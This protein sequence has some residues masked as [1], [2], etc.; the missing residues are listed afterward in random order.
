MSHPH[1]VQIN[2]TTYCGGGFTDDVKAD[3]QVFQYNSDRN[4]WSALPKCPTRYHALVELNGNLIT[5]GGVEHDAPLGAPT[6]SVYVLEDLQWRK[7]MPP[8][9][10]ARYYASA[11]TYDS[12]AIVCGGVTSW[13]SVDQFTCTATVEVYSS[14]TNQWAMSSPL[15]FALR[16]MSTAVVNDSHWRRMSR[17]YGQGGCL[18]PTSCTNEISRGSPSRRLPTLPLISYVGGPS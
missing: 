18:C 2:N 14:D 11:I 3:R 4:E 7:T 6:N 13:T 16:C 1:T 9:A 8:L 15:P 10:T 12:H 17:R 5:I